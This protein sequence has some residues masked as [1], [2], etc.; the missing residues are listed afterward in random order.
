[1]V[2]MISLITKYLPHLPLGT[3]LAELKNMALR[4]PTS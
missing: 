2:E 1:M 3:A 4:Q